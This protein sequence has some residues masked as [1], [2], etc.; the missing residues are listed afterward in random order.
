M[1]KF[2]IVMLPVAAMMIFA[3]C[4][5]Y[6]FQQKKPVAKPVAK[7]AAKPVT[8]PTPTTARA[9]ETKPA[10]TPKTKAPATS[11]ADALP[12]PQ[13]T[14]ATSGAAE[15]EFLVENPRP[16]MANVNGKPIYIEKLNEALVSDYGLPIAR[17][18]VADEVVRQELLNRNLS[19]KVTDQEI[20]QESLRS[21]RMLFPLEDNISDDQFENILDQFL[22]NYRYT[23]RQWNQTMTRN[24]LLSRLVENNIPV[25]DA[26]LQEAFFRKYDGKYTARFIQVDSLEKA[27]DVLKTLKDK[28]V[29]FAVLAQKESINMAAK[30]GGLF[31]LT[32]KTAPDWIPPAIVKVVRSMQVGQISE[33]V[34]AGATFHII[35]LESKT[36]PSSVK[37]DDVKPDLLVLVRE[38][39]LQQERQKYLAALMQKAKIEFVDPTLRTQNEKM[40]Q[41]A[42]SAAT[43]E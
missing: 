39:K 30:D 16:V 27:Q 5:M 42:D 34:M 13:Q 31:E 14:A 22:R 3:G 21:M 37:L 33:P 6:M 8:Q 32:T 9:A 26:E 40:L 10:T 38:A 11:P 2:L 15:V 18:F 17:Q 4:D 43:A 35:K 19:T 25:T 7:P 23:R 41:K 24:V 12:A 36:P 1:K 28:K 29:D 20:N